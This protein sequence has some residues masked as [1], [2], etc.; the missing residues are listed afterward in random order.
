MPR[1]H[2][3]PTPALLLDLDVL[4]RNVERMA[5]TARRLGVDLRPHFKTSKCVEVARLQR[6]RGAA[7]FTVAT[8][9][10]ARVLREHGFDDLTWAFPVIPSRLAE[11]RDLD[12]PGDGVRLRLT[13]D[14]P[15]AVAAVEATGHPFH[16]WLEVDSGDHRSGVDPDGDRALDLARRLAD[17]RLLTFDGLLT[18]GGQSYEARGRAELERIAET[19]RRIVAGLAER[20]RDTGL[21]VPGVSV[22]STPGMSAVEHL[23]GVTEARPGNYVFYDAMQVDL[24]SCRSSD[25]AVTVLTTVVSGQPGAEHSVVDAGALALSKD[26]G[27]KPRSMGRFVHLDR[28]GTLR[29]DVELTALSQEHGTANAPLPVGAKMRILPNHSCLTVACWD[30]VHAVRGEDVVDRWRIHRGR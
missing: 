20:L 28:P 9:E 12:R 2:D 21:E 7:G 13:V 27:T 24:G 15:E 6:D 8:L 26:S 18:H 16:V 19:E 5:E 4:E 1:T 25:C 30:H 11:A 29:W 10:E 17:S 14:T 22:G 23:D 3:L